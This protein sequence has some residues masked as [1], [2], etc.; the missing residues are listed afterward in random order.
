[1]AEAAIRVGLDRSSA[2]RFLHQ[3]A[4]PHRDACILLA[5]HFEANPK[6]MLETAGYEPIALF[7]M[8]L[9]DPAECPPEVKVLAQTLTDIP[10]AEKR[11]QPCTLLRSLVDL[12]ME[13]P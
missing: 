4:R 2:W 11:R 9:A 7:E 13:E 12:V 10:D 1:M 8:S 5:Q 6:E 3:A